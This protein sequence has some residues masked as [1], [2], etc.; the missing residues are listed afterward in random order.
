MLANIGDKEMINRLL[1]TEILPA[2]ISKPNTFKSTNLF[3]NNSTLVA[4]CSNNAQKSI[5]I[6]EI[7]RTAS[8]GV[9]YFLPPF[10][11]LYPRYKSDNPLAIYSTKAVLLAV[12]IR[13]PNINVQSIPPAIE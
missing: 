7:L 3:E 6:I 1:A 5:T 9:R 10:I 8:I 13:Y 2:D 4:V 11:A 12:E